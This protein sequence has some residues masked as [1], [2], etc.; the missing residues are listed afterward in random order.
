M[1]KIAA[2]MTAAEQIVRCQE[3]HAPP[4][5]AA[6]KPNLLAM[7][8]QAMEARW[9]AQLRTVAPVMLDVTQGMRHITPA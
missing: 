9:R 6:R 5:W 3:P 8:R 4:T 1:T 2:R 7:R